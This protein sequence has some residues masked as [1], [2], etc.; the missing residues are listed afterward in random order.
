MRGRE[1]CPWGEAFACGGNGGRYSRVV[2]KKAKR[3]RRKK[4]EF[5]GCAVDFSIFFLPFKFFYFL[6]FSSSFLS[7]VKANG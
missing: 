7:P 5:G 2:E 1:R 6:S 3:G 4:E